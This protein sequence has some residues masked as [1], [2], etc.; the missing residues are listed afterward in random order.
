MALISLKDAVLHRGG[1]DI[2][3]PITWQVEADQRWVL[4]GPNGAGKTSLL[5]LISAQTHPTQGEVEVLDQVLG[6]VDVFDLR[7]RIGLMS[8]SVG[9]NLPVDEKV[10][11]VVLTA[12][13]GIVGR[14]RE[15]YE[16]WDESRATCLLYTS[17]AADE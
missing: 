2:L 8:P 12:S 13:Y 6:K 15:N 7:P 3:G 4:L 5:S 17:D 10:M 14:W 1:K 11:D 16:L 9:V